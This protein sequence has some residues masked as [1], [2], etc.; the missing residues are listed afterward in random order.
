MKFWTN[1]KYNISILTLRLDFA[2]G[3]KCLRLVA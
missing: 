3:G 2:C 1:A